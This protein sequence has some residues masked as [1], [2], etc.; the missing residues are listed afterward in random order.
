ME[1]LWSVTEGIFIYRQQTNEI[2]IHRSS[3]HRSSAS[4]FSYEREPIVFA[5]GVGNFTY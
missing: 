1:K 3:Q 4:A 2:E 5:H